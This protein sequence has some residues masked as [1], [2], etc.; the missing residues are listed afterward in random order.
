MPSKSPSIAI[1]II[2]AV[3]YILKIKL[4]LYD[5]SKITILL[6]LQINF[7]VYQ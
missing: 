1:G 6:Y 4:Y 2:S 7:I 3:S 5:E